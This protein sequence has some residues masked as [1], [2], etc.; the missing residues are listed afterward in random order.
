MRKSTQLALTF[1]AAAGLAACGG[2]S[3]TATT[4]AAGPVAGQVSTG[5]ITAFGSIFVNGVEYDIDAALASGQVTVNGQ[6]VS[7]QAELDEGMKVTVVA[8]ASLPNGQVEARRVAYWSDLA[9]WDDGQGLPVSI[10]TTAGTFQ[11][12]GR[13]VRVD[14]LTVFAVEHG[15][16][17]VTDLAG[18]QQAIQAETV[19]GVEVSGLPDASGQILATRI[20]I[21]TTEP[22]AGAAG[23][24]EMHGVVR[25][26]D[27]AAGR[28]E[29]AP[30]AS[31]AQASWTA[32]IL[33]SG[34][35]VEGTLSDGVAVEVQGSWDPGAQVFTARKVEVAEG[36]FEQEL[37]HRRSGDEGNHGSGEVELTGLVSGFDAGAQ[38]FVVQ[39]VTVSYANA[40]AESDGDLGGDHGGEHGG[41]DGH[42]G[43]GASVAT[44]LGDG[45]LV[46]VEGTLDAGGVLVARKVEV[47]RPAASGGAQVTVLVKRE[48][49]IV[50]VD[51]AARTIDIQTA[52]GTTVTVKLTATTLFRDER[53]SSV[54]QPEPLNF[55]TAFDTASGV[56]LLVNHRVE[57]YGT[58][59]TA[60]TVTALRLEAKGAAS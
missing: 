24:H 3:G 5:P 14:A 34:A 30:T 37:H 7:S 10:D 33:A 8:G 48:G 41:D 51:D 40:R 19:T 60:G 21:K 52:P 9:A 50:G 39:G 15:A 26:W 4:G 44:G 55:N 31:A 35:R 25:N 45:A 54:G 49:P 42:A 36:S 20:E 16:F 28:F 47:K 1:L 17:Q 32:V 12:L 27:Q 46:E 6:P 13:T 11:L 22:A 57:V 53:A 2:G 29:L 38:T 23:W 18:L 43:S 59:D 58:L 56:A